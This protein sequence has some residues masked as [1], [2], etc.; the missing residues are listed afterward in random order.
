MNL[1]QI[2]AQIEEKL[3]E[4]FAEGRSSGLPA[5]EDSRAFGAMVEKTI[6]DEWDKICADLGYPPLE[7]PGRKTLYDFAF[8]WEDATVGIDVKTKDLDST[9]YSDGGVCSVGN[10]LK[11]LANDSGVFLI[12]EFGHN[13]LPMQRERRKLAYIRVA[14]FILLPLDTY[15]IEN[16]GTGQVRLD[17]T[18]NQIWDEIDWDREITEFYDM[19]IERAAAHYRRVS[20]V[21]LNR[22]NDLEAFKE[23]GYKDFS[24]KR[25]SS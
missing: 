2:S 1:K 23:N 18:V 6:A 12:A 3:S 17:C 4:I 22:I 20:Q 9:S 10:L 21:A 24:F 16:L 19:F 15:R 13:K 11:F 8:R 5:R 7:R 25:T 14:P